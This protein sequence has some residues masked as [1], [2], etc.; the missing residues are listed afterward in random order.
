MMWRMKGDIA[1][2]ALPQRTES[3]SQLMIIVA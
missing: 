1:R 2:N 3:Q